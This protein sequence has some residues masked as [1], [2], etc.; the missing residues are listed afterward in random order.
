MIT[1]NKQYFILLEDTNK[2]FNINMHSHEC[3][4]SNMYEA[5]G[6]MVTSR[7]EFKNRKILKITSFDFTTKEN[8]VEYIESEH[9]NSINN[10]LEVLNNR[11]K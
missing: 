11:K 5:I 8:L 3:F 7:T 9:E 2:S 6:K 4:A 1:I 10:A